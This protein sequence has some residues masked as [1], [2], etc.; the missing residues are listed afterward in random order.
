MLILLDKAFAKT[1]ISVLTKIFLIQL[2]FNRF[3]EHMKSS[4]RVKSTQIK[5][6][7]NG[8]DFKVEFFRY[9]I[10]NDITYLNGSIKIE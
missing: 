1:S 9:G 10:N 3:I 5:E 4:T 7:P 6:I 2:L 8:Y